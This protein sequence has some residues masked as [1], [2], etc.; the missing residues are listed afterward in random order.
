METAKNE[1]KEEMKRGKK[2]MKE[3]KEW[4]RGREVRR[5]K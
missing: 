3:G 4:K 5:K 2:E 1:R